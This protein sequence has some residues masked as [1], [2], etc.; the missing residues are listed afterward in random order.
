MWGVGDTNLLGGI[1]SLANPMEFTVTQPFDKAGR[2]GELNS[3]AGGGACWLRKLLRRTYD[4]VPVEDL[5][6]DDVPG[7]ETHWALG[8]NDER[9]GAGGGAHQHGALVRERR[10]LKTLGRERQAGQ[11]D[12]VVAGLRFRSEERRV[13]KECRSRWSPYH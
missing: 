9:V 3:G 8:Q 5:R 6:F 10:H 7:I 1:A 11:D 4:A 2:R 13:G 12:V